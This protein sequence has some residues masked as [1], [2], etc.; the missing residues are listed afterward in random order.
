MNFFDLIGVE[1][2]DNIDISI[3]FLLGLWQEEVWGFCDFVNVLERQAKVGE[4]FGVISDLRQTHYDIPVERILENPL[5]GQLDPFLIL[6]LYPILLIKLINLL[7]LIRIKR[8]DQFQKMLL[9]LGSLPIIN[10]RMETDPVLA[11]DWDVF[12]D[13]E[14]HVVPMAGWLPYEGQDL[15]AG[16][17]VSEDFEVLFFQIINSGAVLG[18]EN[19]SINVSISIHNFKQ[20][21]G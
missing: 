3:S 7:G 21:L 11:D 14:K 5:L 1:L 9:C 4:F 17:S 18:E 2:L 19:D 20:P 13:H 10:E 12:L 15:H 16:G 6:H 8:S